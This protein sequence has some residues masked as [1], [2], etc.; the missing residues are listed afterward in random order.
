[1]PLRI[2]L[3]DVAREAGVN[4]STVS[5]ALRNSRR[6]SEPTRNRIQSIA[7][8]MG[9]THDVWLDA[10]LSYR[11]AARR[12]SQRPVLAYV[13]SWP[14]PIEDAPHHRCYWLGAQ[15]RAEELGFRLEHFSLSA[16]GISDERLSSILTARG[17]DGVVLSSFAKASDEVRF[18]WTRFSVVRIELQPAHP[19]FSTTAVDHVH[20]IVTAVNEALRLGYRRPGLMIGHDWSALVEN[21]W[22]IGFY[23]AQRTLASKDHIPIF[24]FNAAW[25]KAIRHYRFAGWFLKYRPDVLLGPFLHIERR[26]GDLNLTVPADVA[27]IDPFLE[28]P[29][30]FYA[31]IVHDFEEVGARAIDQLAVLVTRNARGA[32]SVMVRC[33]VEGAW[34]PGPSC[35]E[36]V[37]SAAGANLPI[38]RVSGENC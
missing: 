28:T 13:T 11:D 26:L 23:G 10:L 3:R 32:P 17:I 9:Y 1:M 16:P 2:T 15:R 12:R 4:V 37:S 14:V 21:H 34:Q 27:V 18:D 36:A 38:A 24:A 31:G 33:Y 22:E 35:P 30:P 7:K 29:H 6:I 8:E 5:L 20:A 25:E 19:A